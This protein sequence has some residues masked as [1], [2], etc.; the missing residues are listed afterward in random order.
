MRTQRG[1]ASSAERST[2][3]REAIGASSVPGHPEGVA[4]RGSASRYS[5]P[6]CWTAST[7][8]RT[9]GSLPHLRGT[10]SS[11]AVPWSDFGRDPVVGPAEDPT[12]NGEGDGGRDDGVDR[13]CR[14]RQVA[15]EDHRAHRLDR[16]RQEV[17]PV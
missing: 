1:T 8:E 6:R 15:V 7:P 12:A 14:S 3:T 10:A 2:P 5:S 4:T 17:D 13:Y 11:K 9:S 16:R